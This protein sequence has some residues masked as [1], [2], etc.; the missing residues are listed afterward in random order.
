MCSLHLSR[1]RHFGNF[2]DIA[3]LRTLHNTT[4][5][6]N[7]SNSYRE[8]DEALFGVPYL[9]KNWVLYGQDLSS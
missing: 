4:S 5:E 2:D 6:C 9:V 1:V 8:V 3:G 7:K